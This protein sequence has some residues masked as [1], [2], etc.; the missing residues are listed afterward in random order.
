MFISSHLKNI[1]KHIR[2]IISKIIKRIY[3]FNEKKHDFFVQFFKLH[4]LQQYSYVKKKS[5]QE[6]TTEFKNFKIYR[7]TKREIILRAPP[8]RAKNRRDLYG[9]P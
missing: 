7:S 3:Y 1:I 2:R 8:K 6:A 5:K 9:K 4:M